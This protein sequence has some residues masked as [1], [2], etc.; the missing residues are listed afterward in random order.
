MYLEGTTAIQ[1]DTA[2]SFIFGVIVENP[3]TDC[4]ESIIAS[5]ANIDSGMEVELHFVFNNNIAPPLNFN[6]NINRVRDSAGKFSALNGMLAH[7]VDGYAQLT[8]CFDCILAFNINSGTIQRR[9]YYDTVNDA[10]GKIITTGTQFKEKRNNQ[11]EVMFTVDGFERP[12]EADL[13]RKMNELVRIKHE[14]NI[15]S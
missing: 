2:H 3:E 14:N 6:S 4:V 1:T 9:I 5:Y 10:A 13:L 15:L 8:E 7:I 11:H 12:S